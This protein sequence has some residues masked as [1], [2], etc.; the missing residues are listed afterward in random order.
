LRL[1]S[2]TDIAKHHRHIFLSPHFDDVV[3]S[4]GGTI[5]LQASCGLHPLVITVFAGLPSAS[6]PLSPYA[7]TI[8]K[9]MGFGYDAQEAVE[10]RRQEDAKALDYLGADYLWLDYPDAIYRGQPPYY[11]R[12][13]ELMGNIHPA[14][15]SIEKE[16]AALLL[17]LSERLPDTVWYAPLGVGHH[18]DHQ[19][20]CSAADRLVQRSANVKFYEDFPYVTH[21]DD[22][23]KRLHE[24][25][26]TLEPAYVEMS[27]LLPLRQ[28][29]AEMYASQIA[30]I[31]GD[32]ESMYRLMD[33][34]THNIRPVETVRLERYWTPRYR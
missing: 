19:I 21:P 13:E 2:V 22:L 25:G 18:V 31:F 17:S 33:E 3:F 11:T 9:E 15:L 26:G 24:L 6:Q 32:K 5:A 23:E 12:Q 29:A 20:V 8:H 30:A 4:C 16:L 14:D 7:L 28:E 10:T 34:Y 1:Q 27:E